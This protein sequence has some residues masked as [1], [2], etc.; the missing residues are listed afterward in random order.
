MTLPGL[1][2]FTYLGRSDTNKYFKISRV[3]STFVK[4][5]KCDFP[6][7]TTSTIFTFICRKVLFL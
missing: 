4:I 3:K 7:D 2:R 6:N 5:H 1:V